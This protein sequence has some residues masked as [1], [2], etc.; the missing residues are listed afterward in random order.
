MSNHLHYSDDDI[1]LAARHVSMRRVLML[2]TPYRYRIAAAIL[3]MI[4]ASA[5]GL[6]GSFLLWAII[7]EALPAN[8]LKLLVGLVV[9]MVIVT[10]L[11][12]A[13][14]AYQ[15]ILMS[16]IGQ[17]VLHALRVRLYSHLQSLSLRFFTGTRVGDVQSRI[18]S[19]IDGL[20]SLV[21]K[22]ANE[23]GRSL[24]AVIMTAIAIVILDWRRELFVF[25]VVPGTILR[26]V[27]ARR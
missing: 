6:E 1:G 13:V 22:I 15:V 2:F 8:D 26:P 10:L 17:A 19:D 4:M 23:L 5:V 20:Q 27:C 25:F 16:R 18:V 11:S 14:G 9:G 24:S 7:D 3:L 21:T 12:A